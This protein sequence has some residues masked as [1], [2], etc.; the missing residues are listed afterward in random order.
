M[1][2]CAVSIHPARARMLD[3][4]KVVAVSQVKFSESFQ[5]ICLRCI[6]PAISIDD[7]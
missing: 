1:I 6:D 7:S 4:N 3:W 5:R 2:L